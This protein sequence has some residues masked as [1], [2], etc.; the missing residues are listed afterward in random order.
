MEVREE[1]KTVAADKVSEDGMYLVYKGKELPT[2]EY[3]TEV[4]DLIKDIIKRK[5]NANLK[6]LY[7]GHVTP[8]NV[9]TIDK[10]PNIDGILIEKSSTNLE[11]LKTIFEIIE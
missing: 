5:Y 4:V 8:S 11:K 2:R 9:R 1:Y 7:G 3:V 6:V 10:T